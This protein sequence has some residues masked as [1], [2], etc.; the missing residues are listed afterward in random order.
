MPTVNCDRFL[1]GLSKWKTQTLRVTAH[2]SNLAGKSVL[3]LIP[4]H[5]F[6]RHKYLSMGA[7]ARN[8]TLRLLLPSTFRRWTV[9]LFYYVV[10]LSPL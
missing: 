3:T 4:F 7:F 9:L 5:R 1:C 10:W 2:K 8:A 6:A